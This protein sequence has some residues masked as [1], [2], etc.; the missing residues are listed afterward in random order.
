MAF[1]DNSGTIIID[2]ILTDIGRKRMAQGKFRI[3]KF[4]LGD[5]EIDYTLA[6]IDEKDFSNLEDL[7]TIEALDS[8]NAVINYGLQNYTSDDILYIP[9]IKVNEVL[10]HAVV[11]YT[12]EPDFYYFAANEETAKKLRSTIGQKYFLENYNFDRKKLIFE[13]GIE[14][15]KL[16][17]NEKARERYILNYNLLDKYFIINCDGRFVDKLLIVKEQ[18]SYFENDGANNIFANFETLQEAPPV[19]LGK[20]FKYYDS[21]FAI[22][23]D[24]HVYDYGTADDNAHS[25]INGPRGTICAINLKLI[26]ELTIE[27]AGTRNFRY[28]KFGKIDQTLF[29]GSNKFDYIDTIVHVQGISSAR[30]LQVP[31]RILRYAGT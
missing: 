17:R 16:P 21:Y 28:Q 20:I 1:L 4:T 23:I 8:S 15:K 18:S 11:K 19:S 13:S 24:N 5:D 9:E 22:G 6:D 27:S 26:E 12:T 10:S 31:V 7:S 30:K 29:G 2:A 25:A 3:S 14:N